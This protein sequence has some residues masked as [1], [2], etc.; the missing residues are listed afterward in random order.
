[1]QSIVLS[2]QPQDQSTRLYDV[3][4]RYLLSYDMLSDEEKQKLEQQVL[5][6]KR[7]RKRHCSAH[8]CLSKVS[9]KVIV[10]IY[11]II[12]HNRS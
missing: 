2:F 4:C 1:M 12:L 10:N 7:T 9:H 11:Y 6:E 8:E 5:A 3:Y